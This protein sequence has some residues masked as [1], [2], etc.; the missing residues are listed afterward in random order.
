MFS[1]PVF[2]S[3]NNKEKNMQYLL[4]LMYMFPTQFYSFIIIITIITIISNIRW[5][6]LIGR[7]A[8][9]VREPFVV[10]RHAPRL[11]PDQLLMS[12]LCAS[13]EPSLIYGRLSVPFGHKQALKLRTLT[14]NPAEFRTLIPRICLTEERPSTD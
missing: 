5:L 6:H 7:G 13:C 9:R 12:S 2:C 14:L 11:H 3:Q 10:R 8:R 4:A 1:L